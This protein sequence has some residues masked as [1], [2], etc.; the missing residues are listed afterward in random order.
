MRSEPALAKGWNVTRRRRQRREAARSLER[1]ERDRLR[2]FLLAEGGSPRHPIR[3]ESASVVET[4]AR[5]MP[6]P[7]CEASSTL[8]EHTAQQV[9]SRRIRCVTMKC[10]TRGHRFTLYFEIASALN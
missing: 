8:L 9:G 4:R 1:L 7:L 6:C 3:I 10:A 5:A 2:L